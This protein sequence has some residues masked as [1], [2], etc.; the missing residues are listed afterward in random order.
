MD[1]KIEWALAGLENEV[2]RL[3]HMPSNHNYRKPGS[4]LFRKLVRICSL[5]KLANVEYH[6]LVEQVTPV[7]MHIDKMSVSRAEQQLKR[8]WH[9]STPANY[10]E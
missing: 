4:L 8:A 6:T 5:A 10:G 1:K 3:A 7:I 2:S 9:G